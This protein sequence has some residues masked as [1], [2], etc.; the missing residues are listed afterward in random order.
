MSQT[1]T[2]NVIQITLISPEGQPQLRMTMRPGGHTLATAV[3]AWGGVAWRDDFLVPLGGR[4]PEPLPLLNG[5][6]WKADRGAINLAKIRPGH[7]YTMISEN[8]GTVEADVNWSVV[9][10][11]G[12]EPVP[13]SDAA[14]ELMATA[15]DGGPNGWYSSASAPA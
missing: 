7:K 4:W 12:A 5:D 13:L 8:L 2:V 6:T 1:E 14:R 9:K 15:T 3:R 11:S 10:Q